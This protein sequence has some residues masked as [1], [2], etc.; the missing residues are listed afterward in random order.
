[1]K[2]I[3]LAMLELALLGWLG[4]ARAQTDWSSTFPSGRTG[5]DS[6]LHFV[7]ET[8]EETRQ[9]LTDCL[10]PSLDDCQRLFYDPKLGRKVYR[11]QRQI[12]RTTSLV[13]GPRLKGQTQLLVWEATPEDLEVYQGEARYFPGGYHE[14]ADA[15]QPDLTFYRFKFVEPGRKLGSAYDIMVYLDGHWR[16]I[17]RPWVVLFE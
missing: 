12:R 13:L 6:M 2:R 11:Y 5:L 17:H 4:A 8:D 14:L 16:L 7:L 1:M 15:F 9:A 3:Y 10:F